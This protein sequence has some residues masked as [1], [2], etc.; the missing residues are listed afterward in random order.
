MKFLDYYLC[1]NEYDNTKYKELCLINFN[2]YY[3]IIFHSTDDLFVNKQKVIFDFFEIKENLIVF[4]HIFYGYYDCQ[5]NKMYG[6][7]FKDFQKLSNDT[8]KYLTQES[9]ND[10][11]K[12]HEIFELII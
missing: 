10:F 1:I 2:D 4:K 6:L 8:P 11:F 7:S 9:L 5:M 3:V 12:K